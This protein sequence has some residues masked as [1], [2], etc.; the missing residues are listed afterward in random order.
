MVG[1]ETENVAADVAPSAD[2]KLTLK[3]R[4]A[5]LDD[6]ELVDGNQGIADDDRSIE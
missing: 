2:Y 6:M 1:E 3:E 5:K 4:M